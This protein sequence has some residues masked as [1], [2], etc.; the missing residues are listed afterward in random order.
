MK[1]PI[2][3]EVRQARAAVA[4]DFG[5]DLHKFFAWAKTHTAAERKAKRWLPTGPN[6]TLETTGGAAKPSAVRK[7]RVRPARVSA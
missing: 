5:Y 4:A 3:Q 6:E 1:D 7:R 2:V